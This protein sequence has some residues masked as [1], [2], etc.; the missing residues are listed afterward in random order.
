MKETKCEY[1]GKMLKED[2]VQTFQGV[3]MCKDCF[4]EKTVVCSW[5]IGKCKN[6]KFDLAHNGILFNDKELR[7]SMHLPKTKIETDSYIAV[8]LIEK[9][10]YLTG[11]SIKSSICNTSSKTKVIYLCINSGDII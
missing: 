2:E 5:C 10:R 8:Q 9:K 4:E 7:K 11:D 1:C 3:M 6:T